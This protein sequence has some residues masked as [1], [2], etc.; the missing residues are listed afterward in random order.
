MNVAIVILTTLAILIAFLPHYVSAGGGSGE[1]YPLH[2]LKPFGITP[3][4]L[5]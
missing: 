4:P 1:G 5:T 2:L 3:V